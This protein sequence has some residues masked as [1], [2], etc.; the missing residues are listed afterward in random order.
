MNRL[1]TASAIALATA[2]AAS[3]VTDEAIASARDK[4][5]VGD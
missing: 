4:T 5:D 2:G 3:G 1:I